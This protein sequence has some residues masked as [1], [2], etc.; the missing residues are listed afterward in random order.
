ME[1]VLGP[2]PTG[3]VTFLF[4]DIEGSTRLLEYLGDDTYGTLLGEHHRILRRAIAEHD[5][6]E[7]ST[8]GDAFFVVFTCADDAVAAALAAQRAL[9]R[10][11]W[12]PGGLV[13]VRMG[14]NTGHA[15]LG[16]DSYIGL[17]VNQAARI[18]SA[19]HGGQVVVSATTHDVVAILPEGASWHPLG[20]HR[21]KDLGAPVELLQLCHP[22]LVAE[23][24]PLRSLE[25]VAHNLPIQTSSFLGRDEELR[26]GAKLLAR[27]R[28][29]CV[30]GPGGT[31]KTRLAYQLAAEHLQE[32][33]DGVWV[34]ELAAVSDA[35]LVAAPLVAALGLRDE[36]GRSATQTIVSHL[37]NRQALV[38]LDNCEHLIAA[39]ASLTNELLSGCRAL[40]VLA[41]SHEPLRVG[42]E[43]VWALRPLAL[44][45]RADAPLEVL[46]ATD[47]ISL[48]CERAAE[49]TVGFVLNAE[50]AGVV[51][52]ICALLEGIPLAI[53]LA[54]ARVRTLSVGQIR[55]RL[56]DRFALLTSG[57]RTIPPRHQTLRALI[58]WSYDLLP[59][60]ERAV[61][62]QLSVFAGGWTLE[63]A[64]AVI[65]RGTLE[66]LSDLV[67]KSMV[68][69][70]HSR[71]NQPRYHLLETIRQYALE[72]LVVTGEDQLVR[73]RHL[74]TW[75]QFAEAAAPKLYG[76]EQE[77]GLQRLESDH[78]NLRAALLWA[79]ESKQC[80]AALHLGSALG[81]FWFVRGYLSE[82]RQWLQQA[83]TLARDS[84]VMER[85]AS[86]E[87]RCYAA[88]LQTDGKLAEAQGDYTT[89]WARNEE[90]LA[91]FRDVGDEPGVALSLH[92]LGVVAVYR[93]E[94]DR[95][96]T[97][98]EE[99]LAIYRALGDQGGVGFS[100]NWLGICA[101]HQGEYAMAHSLHREGLAIFRE[102]GDTRNIAMSLDCLGTATLGEG[103]SAAARAF[104]EESLR[105]FAALGDKKSVAE[106]LPRLAAVAVEQRQPHRAA[107]LLGAVEAIL[108]RIHARLDPA[109]QA[110]FDDTSTAAR[111]CLD[112]TKFAS[113]WAAGRALTLDNAIAY[114]LGSDNRERW[115]ADSTMY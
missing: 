58:D 101:C 29:L 33:P 7:I 94:Y 10:G 95:A 79:I 8:D 40:T 78:D 23:L 54:S 66:S 100:L 42:G 113:A 53:E 67:D 52:D 74:E 34:A 81:W 3:T 19:A 1:R 63:A 104:H 5:G 114:A 92:W 68:A 41:T 30:T 59:E 70:D 88:A 4:T 96:R 111:A 89:T 12:P 21:L 112:E 115:S 99:C 9:I 69:A 93:G 84:T 77:E 46:A 80:R 90:G 2:L 86:D 107:Q 14:L 43:T 39:A 98:H 75:L 72:R 91:I 6:T 62:R 57:G 55:G 102:L 17:A 87:R 61:L 24:P 37:R 82:G 106:C 35:A 26:V 97:L 50:N 38:V 83:L 49:A 103:D 60:S 48:F 71:P 25:R 105:V 13:R 109:E 16:G 47:A 85:A 56:N 44:P 73:T 110:G 36:A 31:G 108:E 20:R 28:L 11:A 65:G 64:E 18:A 76:P 22:D 32:F 15:R 51:T 27:T 45:Q